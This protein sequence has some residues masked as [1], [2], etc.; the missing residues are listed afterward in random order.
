MTFKIEALKTR[1]ARILCILSLALGTFACATATLHQRVLDRPGYPRLHIEDGGRGRGVPV[2]FVH[3]IGGESGQWKAQLT[4]LRAHRRAI[5]FDLRG[6]G[7]SPV[8][9]DSD[10]T[11]AAMERDLDAVVGSLGIRRF[12]LVGHS[13]GGAVAARYAATHPDRV[14]GLVLVEPAAQLNIPDA[15][16]KQLGDALRNS[17]DTL[18]PQLFGPAL[19]PSSAEVKSAVFRSIAKSNPDAFA[20][21]FLGLRD[22]DAKAAVIAYRGPRLLIAASAIEQPVSFQRQFAEYPVRRVD[23][24]GHWLMLDRPDE[25]NRLLLEFIEKV[26]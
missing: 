14:A 10:Y 23:G 11:L 19:A 1:G 16:A 8:A 26:D 25:L 17:R 4:A 21:A 18:V 2:I 22:F 5:A 13:Y 6:M 12:V 20:G 24:A 15:A 9:A 7:A 3:G